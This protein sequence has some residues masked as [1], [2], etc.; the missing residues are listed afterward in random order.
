M[1]GTRP[2]HRA[3]AGNMV[4]LVDWTKKKEKKEIDLAFE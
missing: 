1:E 2:R 3:A 4:D